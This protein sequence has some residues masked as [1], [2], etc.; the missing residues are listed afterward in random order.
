MV[1]T[2]GQLRRFLPKGRKFRCSRCPI[3][4]VTCNA[5]SKGLWGE[6]K[7]LIRIVLREILMLHARE[8]RLKHESNKA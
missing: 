6:E 4:R 8:R 3:P 1:M 7:C 2:I 5:I